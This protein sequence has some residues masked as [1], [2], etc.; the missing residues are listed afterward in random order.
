[1]YL[2]VKCNGGTAKPKIEKITVKKTKTYDMKKVLFSVIVVLISMTSCAQ[3]QAGSNENTQKKQQNE[4]V[5]Y[6]LYKT[7]NMWT[8]IKL[9]TRTGKM[10]QIQYDTKG[11]N[12][13]ETYLNLLPLVSKENE[14]NGRF[15]LH[16]TENM[17]TFILLDQIDGRMWQ[18]QWSMEAEKRGI[19]GQIE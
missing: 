1:V 8:F 11:S 4:A 2:R 18:V 19:I 5:R 10:W 6:E 16:S 9:D 17:W 7:Q 3:N 12:R 13:F 14:S 15:T